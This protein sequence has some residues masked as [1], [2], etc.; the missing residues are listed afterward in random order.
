MSEQE[1]TEIWN[2]I[3]HRLEEKLQYGVLE[4]AKAV[5]DIKFSGHE[6]TLRV[7]TDEAFDFFSAD[8]NQQRLIIIGRPDISIERVTVERIEASPTSH[9]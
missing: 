1:A 8:V 5:V 3:V 9:E 6:L 7:A 4:H 2:R